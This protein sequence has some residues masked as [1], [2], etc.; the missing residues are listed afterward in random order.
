MCVYTYNSTN[1]FS[2]LLHTHTHT[3]AHQTDSR[4][5]TPDISRSLLFLRSS[6]VPLLHLHRCSV[7]RH[8]PRVASRERS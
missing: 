1:S 7:G 5:Q 3:S 6:F 8:V 4:Q 2:F